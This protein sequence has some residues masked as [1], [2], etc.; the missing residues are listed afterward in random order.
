M[1]VPFDIEEAPGISGIVRTE[2][3]KEARKKLAAKVKAKFTAW[4]KLP[5]Q[6]C[7]ALS[8]FGGMYAGH[9][10]EKTF[11]AERGVV[12]T[13]PKTQ[14]NELEKIGRISKDLDVLGL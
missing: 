13:L 7:V 1:T 14:V 3:Q 5:K 8:T 10:G 4:G 12:L 2:K 11:Q 9:P 6:K